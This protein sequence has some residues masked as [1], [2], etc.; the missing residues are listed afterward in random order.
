MN[1]RMPTYFL[2]HGS[3]PF[4]QFYNDVVSYYCLGVQFD[5]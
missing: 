1:T 5:Y 4:G 3:A 2:S